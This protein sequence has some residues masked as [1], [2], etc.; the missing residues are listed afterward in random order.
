[1]ESRVL[2]AK[3]VRQTGALVG[4][5]VKRLFLA[6]LS[7]LFALTVSLPQI[8]VKV[9]L[10]EDVFADS[11]RAKRVSLGLVTMDGR[12]VI[13]TRVRVPSTVFKTEFSTSAAVVSD[14]YCRFV[15]LEGK[16]P[17]LYS[18]KIRLGAAP[19]AEEEWS[20]RSAV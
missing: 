13:K 1:M 10:E 14:V 17:I 9:V 5:E 7:V 6:L 4:D 2:V 20:R 16:D 19:T 3:L 18:E 8:P 12:P 11:V 15:V